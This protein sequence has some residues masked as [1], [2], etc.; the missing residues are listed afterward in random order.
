MK[1]PLE[2]RLQKSPDKVFEPTIVFIHNFGGNYASTKRHQEMVLAMGFDCF[3][4][5]FSLSSIP[6]SGE[7]MMEA[8]RVGMIERW[9]EELET[10][11]ECIEGP[12]ILFTFS[13][14]SIALPA[15]LYKQRRKD[16]IGWVCDGGPFE[17]LWQNLWHFYSFQRPEKFKALRW[18]RTELAWVVFGGIPYSKRLKKWIP[19]LDPKLPIFSVREGADQ[20]VSEES[21]DLLF[22][23]NLDLNLKKLVIPGAGHLDG[24]KKNPDVYKQ[25]VGE[26]LKSISETIQS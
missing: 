11:L 15:L 7:Q 22:S 8:L 20:L 17:H 26:F 5:T 25:H 13:F 2:G 1:Y 24:L 10:V 9:S 14:P 12:K 3:S 6:L 18:I 16:V 4:F 19:A 23:Y 21:I